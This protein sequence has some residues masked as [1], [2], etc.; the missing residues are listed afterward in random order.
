MG[1]TVTGGLP[2]WRRGGLQAPGAPESEGDPEAEENEELTGFHRRIQLH[3][4]LSLLAFP[5]GL[6]GELI[7]LPGGSVFTSMGAF[8]RS[9]GAAYS[10]AFVSVDLQPYHHWIPIYL[11]IGL[12]F[13]QLLWV[14]Q[15]RSNERR[16]PLARSDPGRP[17]R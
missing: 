8:L 17:T 7:P 4:L 5:L 12:G 10:V 1:R 14:L 13:W 2:A 6:F 3:S 15:N 16:A 9:A 11:V